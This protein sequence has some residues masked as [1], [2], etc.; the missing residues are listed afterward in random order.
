[1]TT[2][3][4]M[5]AAPLPVP[6]IAAGWQCCRIVP[7]APKR[8]RLTSRNLCMSQATTMPAAEFDLTRADSDRDTG[9]FQVAGRRERPR[10]A[11]GNDILR[12]QPW[13]GGTPS[14]LS[15][16]VAVLPPALPPDCVCDVPRLREADAETVSGVEGGSETD[17]VGSRNTPQDVRV[18]RMSRSHVGGRSS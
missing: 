17:T 9:S 7:S 2:M 6:L 14:S 8:L 12:F 11:A 16:V 1:M 5:C 13:V 10:P 3:T 18:L 4:P 15:D